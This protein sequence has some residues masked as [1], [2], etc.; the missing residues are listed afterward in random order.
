MVMPADRS[1]PG[2]VRIE[3]T[4]EDIACGIESNCTECPIALALRRATTR[5]YHVHADRIEYPLAHGG[6]YVPHP[7]QVREWIG[8]FDSG[9]R[10][11]PFGFDLPE[12]A[13]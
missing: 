3:V 6:G 10:V 8:R 4:S 5:V 1:A 12:L 9:Q 2:L 11:D 7:P 13:T